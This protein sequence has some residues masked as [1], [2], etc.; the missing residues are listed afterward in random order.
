MSFS[1]RYTRQVYFKTLPLRANGC[2]H[3]SCRS[4]G[5]FVWAGDRGEA[6]QFLHGYRSAW[7]PASL[8][9]KDRQGA[10][11]DALFAG[12]RHWGNLLAFQQGSCRGIRKRPGGSQ[13]HCDESRRAG[14]LC[15][16]DHR[17][18]RSLAVPR[19]SRP[20]T[21]SDGRAPRRR[22]C[23]DVTRLTRCRRT[24]RPPDV[25]SD[26][27]IYSAGEAKTSERSYREISP[28]QGRDHCRGVHR[29]EVADTDAAGDE[30]LQP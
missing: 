1:T 18:Q 26:G 2:G 27:C 9:E 24:I 10:L 8:L 21:G 11:V 29:G 7:L 13:R 17:R 19:Y 14:R 16:G 4:E 5:N 3:T 23:A 6:G 22:I 20:R 30:H 28:G 15:P 25:D 12:S